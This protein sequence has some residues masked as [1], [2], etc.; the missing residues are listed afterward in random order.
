MV[1]EAF[2]ET[3]QVNDDDLL[4]ILPTAIVLGNII[5]V[6]IITRQ[7]GGEIQ[8]ALCLL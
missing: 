2:T 5:L 6:L 8:V 7:S 1:N 3:F 4:I